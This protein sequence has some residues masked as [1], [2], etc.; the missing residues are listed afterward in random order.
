VVER[1]HAVC[2]PTASPGWFTHGVTTTA[3]PTSAVGSRG[4]LDGFCAAGL[5]VSAISPVALGAATPMLLAHHDTLLEALS[6][7]ALSIVTGG[8]LARVGRAALL[9]VVLAPLCGILLSDVFFW[10]AGH[11]WGERMVTA[12]KAKHPRSVRWIDRTDGWVLRHGA[13]T[14]AVAY[15][16]PVPNP[17][18]YLSCGTAGMPLVVFLLGDVLGTLLWTGLLVGIG[19]GVGRDGVDV[20]NAIN[21]YELLITAA[22]V[23]VL[24]AVRVRRRR[25]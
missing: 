11:R 9:L 25:R 5:V 21:H 4:R 1:E 6:S 15:F 23:A 12:Y 8:A 17:L 24:I 3:D 19:W 16:L 10:W 20:V 13:R 18:L 2:Y 7:S 14:V 22:I